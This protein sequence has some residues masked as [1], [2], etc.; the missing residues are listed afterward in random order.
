MAMLLRLN[1][2]TLLAAQIRT[3]SSDASQ[4]GELGKGAG[5]GGGA[6]GA[7]REA[8]GEFGKRGASEEEKYFRQKQ[9]EQLKALKNHH[10][11]E[12]Y[13]HEKEIQRLQSEIERH[14]S[15]IKKF[16]HDD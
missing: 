8:G 9:Y 12:I 14:K 7:V 4:L 1:V 15:K 6:G 10:E 13:H 3:M 5:K 11:E 2:R 16:K